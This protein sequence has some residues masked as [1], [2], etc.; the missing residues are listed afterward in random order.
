MGSTQGRL[1]SGTIDTRIN[2]YVELPGGGKDVR[3]AGTAMEVLREWDT[4]DVIVKDMR[5]ER[6]GFSLDV[7]GFQLVNQATVEKS[8]DD[9]ERVKDTVYQEIREMLST[10]LVFRPLSGSWGQSD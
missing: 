5:N 1:D 2:Y 9:D 7:Y 8:F 6:S 3:Y 4:R 10:T